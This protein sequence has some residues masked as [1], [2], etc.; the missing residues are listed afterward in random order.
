[1]ARRY[2]L[3]DDQ[4][5]RIRDLLPGREGHV[6][7]RRRIIVCS[8]KRCFIDTATGYL[9]AIFPS[10]SE[11]GRMSTSGCADGAKA[12]S[13]DVYSNTWLPI[14]ITNT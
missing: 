7:V 6:G 10:D 2:G 12:A 3:R 13:S 4:W 11:T 8:W 1:M 5:D 14:T 9:G